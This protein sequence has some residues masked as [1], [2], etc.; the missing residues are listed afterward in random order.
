ML[1]LELGQCLSRMLDCPVVFIF[2]Y[3]SKQHNTGGC[4]PRDVYRSSEEYDQILPLPWL[5]HYT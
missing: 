4:D 5:P 2:Y 1:H 3:I